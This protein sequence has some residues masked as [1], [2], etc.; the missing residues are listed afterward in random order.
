MKKKPKIDRIRC[1]AGIKFSLYE[2]LSPLIAD[3]RTVPAYEDFKL[4]LAPAEN[5]HITLKFLGSVEAENLKYIQSVMAEVGN[6]H[7]HFKISA[8]GLGF[9][10]NSMWIGIERN[11]YLS[12]IVSEMS[13]LFALQEYVEDPRSFTPHI[14]LLR[15]DHSAKQQLQALAETYKDKHWGEFEVNQIHLYKSETLEEG[16]RSTILNCYDFLADSA[17]N[18]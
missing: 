10:K 6:K 5:L 12:A 4:R 13:R 16:A 1:F 14:T 2:N 7:H 18:H 3:L 15:F 9:F 11:D 8:S 17:D